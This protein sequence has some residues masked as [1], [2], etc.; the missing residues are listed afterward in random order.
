MSQIQTHNLS[1][2]QPG[3]IK[4]I[5]LEYIHDDIKLKDLKEW[6]GVCN[7]NRHKLV[8]SIRYNDW[9]TTCTNDDTT[10]SA[11][12][13]FNTYLIENAWLPLLH[14]IKSKYDDPLYNIN[15]TSFIDYLK[16]INHILDEEFVTKKSYVFYDNIQTEI[17]IY[18]KNKHDTVIN[19][20]TLINELF[21]M[22]KNQINENHINILK[23]NKF[24]C[25]LTITGEIKTDH[26]DM[27]RTI[28]TTPKKLNIP[29][30]I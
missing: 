28:N 5:I 6:T 27:A 7:Y 11:D 14:S 2:C 16:H 29:L 8:D 1:R 9:M 12:M 3:Y 30:S 26:Q 23:F 13:F 21:V 25:K 15:I 18:Y 17:I 20:S 4:S 22:Y 10:N 24:D 19:Y